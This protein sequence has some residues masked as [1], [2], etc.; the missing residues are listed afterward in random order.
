MKKLSFY[1]LISLSL[2]LLGGCKKEENGTN[3]QSAED[4]SV[5]N[6][7]S[8]NV[9]EIVDRLARESDVHKTS[10]NLP[11]CAAVTIDTIS[12]GRSITFDF[13]TTGCVCTKIDGKTRKGKVIAT[14]TGRY[15]K[16]GSI[17]TLTTTDY[18]VNNYKHAISKS[19]TNK[20]RVDG[21]LTF[22]ITVNNQVET[23]EGT[24]SWASSR[25]R[26]WVAGESTILN[27]SDDQ[28]DISDKT[29]S[30][31][32]NRKGEAFT[33]NIKKPIRINLGC[34]YF[35]T[36]GSFDLKTGT[37]PTLT[38]DYGDGACDNKFTV[39]VNGKTYNLTW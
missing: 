8:N 34:N 13:G 36:E 17:I 19:I 39:T 16:E 21:N 6:T 20:G 9:Y 11:D 18:Y 5:A 26:A 30:V 38:V 24:I 23:P 3:T 32:K 14:W 15:R 2:A 28:Y 25:T 37:S 29:A 10:G 1:L 4:A 27:L 7:E 31:G 35:I 33:S 12:A 22:D